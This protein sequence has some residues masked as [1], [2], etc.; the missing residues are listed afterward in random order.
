MIYF[1]IYFNRRKILS[2]FTTCNKTVRTQILPLFSNP[3]HWTNGAYSSPHNQTIQTPGYKKCKNKQHGYTGEWWNPKITTQS[4]IKSK[5]IYT[6]SE[7]AQIVVDYLCGRTSQ[8]HGLMNSNKT[9]RC[10]GHNTQI[11]GLKII[12]YL[13]ETR[14]VFRPCTK[15]LLWR[16]LSADVLLTLGKLT[17]C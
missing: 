5:Y 12:I 3:Q 7:S 8:A 1:R 10:F 9:W 14:H 15:L 16:G 6:S 4:L 2:D 11:V 17:Y 13:G